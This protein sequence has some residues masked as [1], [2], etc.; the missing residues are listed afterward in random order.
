MQLYFLRH[1]KA[2]DK[3]Q[4]TGPDEQ[5]PLTDEGRE[6]MRAVAG[7]LR[8]LDLKLD[9]ILSSPLVRARQTADY[10]AEALGVG[11][12][13]TPAL[14]PDC[15]LDRLAAALRV[16]R[17]AGAVMLVGHEPDFSTLVGLLISRRGAMADVEMKKAACCR[18]D[19][20]G[21]PLHGD[22]LGGH[23]TLVWLLPP[24]H[25]ALLGGVG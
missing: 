3:T 19:V 15:D 25:L 13:E 22:A 5:R 18:V 20:S 4:W 11:V 24:K 2:G 7:G 14:A 10:A 6:E 12:T 1:G 16:A 8:R 9:T 21:S 23:G 17:S